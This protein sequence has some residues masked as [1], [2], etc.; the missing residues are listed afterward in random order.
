MTT[1]LPYR[2]VVFQP[3]LPHY[4]RPFFRALARRVDGLT[5]VHGA[6]PLAGEVAHGRE[7]GDAMAAVPVGHRRVGPGLWMPSLWRLAADPQ[8]DVCVFS[9]NSRYVH[10][11]AA[12]L[13][14]RLKGRGVVLWGH[15]YSTRRDAA[16]SRMLRNG[17]TRL[18]H[19]VVTYNRRAAR[20]LV[21]AGVPADRVFVAPNALD[22]DPIA[23]ATRMWRRRDAE[24][25]A[26]RRTL[27]IADR[28]V[29]IHVSRLSNA[30]GLH[31]LLE[32]WRLVVASVPRA[33]LLII[34]DGPARADLLARVVELGL[35][36]SVRCLG[37]VYDEME[38]APY[39]LSA[40]IMLH[41][42][43]IG[44]SLNH[45][46]A[47]G[48]G[49]ATFDAPAAHSPEFEALR[50]GINGVVAPAGDVAALA[51][52]VGEVLLDEELGTRLGR[53]ARETMHAHYTIEHM[54]DGF[55][56]AVQCAGQASARGA[57]RGREPARVMRA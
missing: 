47:Y 57:S 23:L 9:W 28:P 25:T 16:G 4:R 2:L 41:P 24:L 51:R 1:H 43:K 36:T 19:A 56:A 33:C 46:M 34:G 15:G 5:L 39:V 30:A 18:A 26:F 50:D 31:T 52:R 3:A 14:A 21:E 54:L 7:D 40:R 45:A 55:L 20:G 13:R 22:L 48:V 53:E 37:A 35:H 29:A 6:A 17:L 12:M 32:T 44:L 8:H 11:P 27:D 49:V 10:L 38:L 42:G